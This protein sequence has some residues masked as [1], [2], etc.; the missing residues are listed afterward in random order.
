MP[1]GQH[2]PHSLWMPK[3]NK[4]FKFWDDHGEPERYVGVEIEFHDFKSTP[5]EALIGELKKVVA[6]WEGD[7]IPD[8]HNVEVRLA[9]ARGD[10][11]E[12]QIYSICEALEN[13]GAKVSELSGLHLHIDCQKLSFRSL[14]RVMCLYSKFEPQLIQTQPWTRMH[15]KFCRAT[16]PD[17]ATEWLKT[18]GEPQ[19]EK[20]FK[21]KA[22]Q[23]ISE[24]QMY[25]FGLGVEQAQ[26]YRA[27]NF[28]SY[29]KYKTIEVRM[30]E[31]SVNPDEIIPWARFWSSFVDV[32]RLLSG[33]EIERFPT[34]LDH[35]WLTVDGEGAD[36]IKKRLD[37]YKSVWGPA[38]LKAVMP[39]GMTT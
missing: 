25:Q 31:G 10:A 1:L 13:M 29:F 35:L 12:Q 9:P 27:V 21:K 4:E 30:H 20:L 8:H 33:P 3:A 11:F 18:T 39:E 34:K 7:I 16:G 24:H 32:A 36:Y 2:V 17:L 28:A 19:R 5:S 37:K 23:T 6:K 26:R 22:L 15:G 38:K 14:G